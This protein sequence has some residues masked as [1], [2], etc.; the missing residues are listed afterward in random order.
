MDYFEINGVHNCV[1]ISKVTLE[2]RYI[3]VVTNYGNTFNSV[4]IMHEICG[5]ISASI[6]QWMHNL[7]GK[8]IFIRKNSDFTWENRH[9]IRNCHKMG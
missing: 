7:L 4:E 6:A 3:Y 1:G 9:F 8:D 2:L 5:L